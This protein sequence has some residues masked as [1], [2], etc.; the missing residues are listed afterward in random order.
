MKTLDRYLATVVAADFLAALAALLAIFSVIHL[1]HELEDV[2]VAQ[3]G[4]RQALWFVFMTL[5]SEAY[6]L[7]PAAALLGGVSALGTLAS[8]N[9]LVSVW[10]AGI[11]P[12]RLIWSV[13]KVTAWLVVAA[14]GVGEFAA[15]PLAQQAAAQRSIV[16]SGGL[17]LST[18]NGF[19][20][21]D[22]SRFI[23][24][25]TPLPGA[26]LHDLYVYQFDAQH[27]LDSFAYARTA[28][29]ANHQWTL[30]ELV[31][32]RIRNDVVTTRKVATRVWKK[33]VSP[34]QLRLLSFP[35][36][37]LS[38]YDLYRSIRSLRARGESPRRYQ[39]AFWKRITLPLITGI[40]MF[41]AVP[42]VLVAGTSVRVG[43]R[44]VLGALLGI[45]FQ[46]FNQ[47]FAEFG[48]VFGLD[49]IASATLPGALA[50]AL[51]LWLM[52]RVR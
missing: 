5:P 1:M 7:F 22:G 20:T 35:P 15:A 28:S 6:E 18:A 34:R 27:R 46:M 12:G 26:Q 11:A 33:F 38:L 23:N 51:G 43:Q 48:L 32:G 49:P 30:E 36:E 14:V 50:L 31:E 52:Q 16:L 45:G 13:M 25:R 10:A 2:G 41:L 40:M 9:E 8:R 44:I 42:L 21:R 39:I 19:W 29:Y 47:T 17:A 37:Y 24:V 3:Y 4:M